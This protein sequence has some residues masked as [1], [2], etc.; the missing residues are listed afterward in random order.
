[1]AML[2]H[3]NV[4]I[5]GEDI[6]NTDFNDMNR[7]INQVQTVLKDE[8]KGN[9]D[10]E[11]DMENSFL[12][13]TKDYL[14]DGTKAIGE[15]VYTKEEGLG[16][17]VKGSAKNVGN[18]GKNIISAVNENFLMDED[19][20]NKTADGFLDDIDRMS[21]EDQLAL[22]KQ[23]SKTLNPALEN[24]YNNPNDLE[25]ALLEALNNVKEQVETDN[26]IEDNLDINLYSGKQ[27][28]EASKIS[29]NGVDLADGV[30]AFYDP[31]TQ[32]IHINV[33]N[34]DGDTTTLL[35][36]AA[37]E[38]SHHTDHLQ[39]KE[40][41]G[42]NGERNKISS[43][44]QKSYEDREISKEEAADEERIVKGEF[45][46][47][48]K[49]Q[50]AAG[51]KEIEF[52]EEAQ[53]AAPLIGA[54]AGAVGGGGLEYAGQVL[55]NRLE[56][57]P[58][59]EALTD[60]DVGDIAT[61]AGKGAALGLVAPGSVVTKGGKLIRTGAKALKVV[62]KVDDATGAVGKLDGVLESAAGVPDVLYVDPKG[63]ALTKEEYDIANTFTDNTFDVDIMKPGDRGVRYFEDGR[64]GSTS[65]PALDKPRPVYMTNKGTADKIRTTQ[66]AVDI[67]SLGETSGARPNTQIAIEAKEQ[68]MIMKGKIKGSS[69]SDAH[70]SVVRATDV[71][72]LQKV[73]SSKKGLN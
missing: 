32:T 17:N 38:L 25:A 51:A 11:L 40:F 72:K 67:L 41:D 31:S 34:W 55:D 1:M 14:K 62:D 65:L 19:D 6:V 52:V 26:K 70:Q 27:L 21:R 68:V 23:Y 71:E 12:T 28:E 18:A 73:P 29:G 53:P 36:V 64:E 49:A 7:D 39:G 47:E 57:K 30:Q 50:L 45:S 61:E 69:V 33:D 20:E 5:G 8:T 4:K 43:I 60:V 9:I 48:A 59:G 42:L 10:I 46:A 24:V 16:G 13:D 63:H 66:D 3:G 15:L 58:W 2:G 35:S 54:A 22:E 37:N 44:S 56:G